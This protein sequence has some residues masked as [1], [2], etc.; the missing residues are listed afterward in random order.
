MR[1]RE[2]EREGGGRLNGMLYKHYEKWKYELAFPLCY[3]ER[4]CCVGICGFGIANCDGYMLCLWWANDKGELVLEILH[5]LVGSVSQEQLFKRM[6][7]QYVCIQM[8]QN[9]DPHVY[10]HMNEYCAGICGHQSTLRHFYRCAKSPIN[11]SINCLTGPDPF[12]Y[13]LHCSSSSST[14]SFLLLFRCAALYC[15]FHFSFSRSVQSSLSLSSDPVVH[16]SSTGCL[17]KQMNFFFEKL[18]IIA[19]IHKSLLHVHRLDT[20][21]QL[22]TRSEPAVKYK[23]KTQQR[24]NKPFFSPTVSENSVRINL[25][26]TKIGNGLVR[27][28]PQH[29]FQSFQRSVWVAVK[30]R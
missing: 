2:S 1:P 28:S 15:L 30:Q 20:L 17:I 10:E 27:L 5:C 24:I 9:V 23:K 8:E 6:C 14:V 7:V 4:L 22:G 19:W 13:L 25:V 26:N 21:S 12:I 16:P 18:M 11:N 29:S 3:I